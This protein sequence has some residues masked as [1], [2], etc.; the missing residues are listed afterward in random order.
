MSRLSLPARAALVVLFAA[1]AAAAQTAPASAAAPSSPSAADSADPYVWLE[2]VDSPEA[3]SWV[4]AEN[5]KSLSVLE[6]DPRFAAFDEQALAI[7]QSNDRI[8]FGHQVDGKVWNFWQD[9]GHVRGIW[10]MTSPKDYDAGGAPAW[11]TVLDLDTVA[12]AEHAN[13]VWEGAQCEARHENMCL[14][15]LSDGGEDAVTVREFDL[16][17]GRFVSGGFVLPK[18]K[19]SSAWESPDMLVVA[20]EWKPGELTASGYAYVV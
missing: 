18:S 8:P 11:K 7:A 10:R 15:S 6:A 14:L 3:M 2:K 5:A 17:K 20:R 4:R 12:A 13:W 1:G 19:Q 16:R 9:A